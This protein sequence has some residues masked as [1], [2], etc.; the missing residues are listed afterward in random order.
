MLALLIGG[1]LAGLAGAFEVAGV[2]GRLYE[3]I[4]AGTGYTAIAVALLARL[5]P[6]AVV[7]AALFFGALEAGA[8]AMQREAGVPAEVTQVVQGLVILLSA[9]LALGRRAPRNP[10]GAAAEAS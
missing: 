7:P 10:S 9:A 6:L 1:A 8:G 2:T 5:S 3:G 4:S